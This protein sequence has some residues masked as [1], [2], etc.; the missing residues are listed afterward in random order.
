MADKDDAIA[1]EQDEEQQ[2]QL[3]EE[4]ELDAREE[5]ELRDLRRERDLN[6][7]E[8]A[9]AMRRADMAERNHQQLRARA[10]DERLLARGD[11]AHA[12]HLRDGAVG[13]DDAQSDADL[14]AA[15]RA[16]ARANSR[17]RIANDD[18]RRANWNYAEGRAQRSRAEAVAAEAPAADAVRNGPD[19]PPVARKNIKPLRRRQKEKNSKALRDFGIG[20]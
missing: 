12:A 9:D 10:A 14:R 8:L 18:D 17:D 16:Q 7:A 3:R 5:R 11:S 19:E 20:D 4:L 6:D 15:D 1:D 2:E 13:R